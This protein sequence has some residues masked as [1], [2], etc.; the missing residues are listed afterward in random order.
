MQYLL[1][2]PNEV[3][4]SAEVLA[5]HQ[6]MTDN[7]LRVEALPV[8]ID[9]DADNQVDNTTLAKNFSGEKRHGY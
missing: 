6:K 9:I 8:K 4:L 1:Q 5:C 7:V 3:E 2:F